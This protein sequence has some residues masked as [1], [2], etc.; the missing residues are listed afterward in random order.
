MTT[1]HR[2]TL[3]AALVGSL[4]ISMF[5][6]VAPVAAATNAG[7]Q[8]L[9]QSE[10]YTYLY[11]EWFLQKHVVVEQASYFVD[12]RDGGASDAE[13][14]AD[15]QTE[16]LDADLVSCE[17]W[18]EILDSMPAVVDAYADSGKGAHFMFYGGYWNNGVRYPAQI[19]S[20]T[21]CIP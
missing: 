17:S 19:F 7:G 16:V 20:T 8:N 4:S 6:N 5:T 2:I 14:C 11:N 9:C 15:I 10:C 13:I 12:L 21:S 1:K 18:V 3:I